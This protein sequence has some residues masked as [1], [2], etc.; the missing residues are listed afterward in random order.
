VNRKQ[1]LQRNRPQP[2]ACALSLRDRRTAA[3]HR[4]YNSPDEPTSHHPHLLKI[5]TAFALPNKNP[6]HIKSLSS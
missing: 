4:R 3:N 1:I 6:L 5:I 2:R